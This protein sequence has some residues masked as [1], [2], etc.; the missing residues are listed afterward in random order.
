MSNSENKRK[1]TAYM[2]SPHT[3]PSNFLANARGMNRDA[4]NKG[5]LPVVPVFKDEAQRQSFHALASQKMNEKAKKL[6]KPKY[7]KDA[8][9]IGDHKVLQNLVN[10]S[11]GG[12]SSNARFN[13]AGIHPDANVVLQ[14][15]GDPGDKGIYSDS[16]QRVDTAAS[17]KL[18]HKMQLPDAN[19]VRANS[20]F[21]GTEENILTNRPGLKQHFLAGDV[22]EHFGGNWQNTFAGGLEKELNRLNHHNK[23]TGFLGP[24]TQFPKPSLTRDD[25][26]EE[27]MAVDIMAPSG[28][29]A[30]S[31]KYQKSGMS[32][33]NPAVKKTVNFMTGATSMTN[34]QAHQFRSKIGAIHGRHVEKFKQQDQQELQQIAKTSNVSVSEAHNVRMAQRFTGNESTLKAIGS[35]TGK[36]M[37]DAN[38]FRNNVLKALNKRTNNQ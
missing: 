38:T 6:L 22:D 5:A 9:V 2:V 34:D 11:A 19:E 4:M 17:A 20:C 32:K 30:D 12:P 14:G 25:T 7:A 28:N 29:K 1:A 26:I 23:V 13:L 33:I 35:V 3:N 37:A 15:H 8:K 31:V 24:T 36:S 18:L 16:D 10:M 27:H 21:S